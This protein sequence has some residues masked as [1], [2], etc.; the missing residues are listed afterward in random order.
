MTDKAIS[1]EYLLFA[2]DDDYEL[3]EKICLRLDGLCLKFN[4]S[5]V[6]RLMVHKMLIEGVQPVAIAKRLEMKKNTVYKI[7]RRMIAS[8]LTYY[9]GDNDGTKR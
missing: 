2:C 3:A 8:G 5:Q 1:A 6:K 9:T 7:R 4:I